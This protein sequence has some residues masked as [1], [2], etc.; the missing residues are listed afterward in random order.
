ME[1]IIVLKLMTLIVTMVLNTAFMLLVYFS[2]PKSIVGRLFGLFCFS[3]MMWLV[4]NFIASEPSTAP[5]NIFWMRLGLFFAVPQV[6]SFFLFAKAFPEDKLEISRKKLLLTMSFALSVCYIAMSPLS[7]SQVEMVNGSLQ[8]VPSFGFPFFALFAFGYAAWSVVILYRKR[9]DDGGESRNK[10]ALVLFAIFAMFGLITATIL[11][12]I[13]IWGNDTFIPFG[14]LYTMIFF[15]IV[16]FAIV[17]HRLFNIKLIATEALVFAL[18]TIYIAKIFTDETA[19][20]RYVDGVIFVA[21]LILG[22]LLTKSVQKEV[23]QREKL[24]VLTKELEGKNVQLQKL[25]RLKSEFLSFASHQVKSPMAV[26]KGYA[27]LMIDGSL[28]KASDKVVETAGKMKEVADRLIKLVNELL[29]L[30]K[31]EEG[32]MTFDMADVDMVLV[33]KSYVDELQTLAKQKKLKLT[34]ES[35]VKEAHVNADLQK[36]QQVVQNLIDNSIKYTPEGWIKVSVEEKDGQI[37]VSVSDSGLGMSKELLDNL[38]E[39]FMRDKNSRKIIQGT[40][41]GLYIAKQIVDG[42]GG[43]IWAESE[44]EGKGSVMRFTLPIL[45]STKTISTIK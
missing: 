15:G 28:G 17:K 42:H 14:P 9:N 43:K 20:A 27:Q 39:A 44:G 37:L 1:F 21:L 34:F 16:A 4:V 25:D 12:P 23:E 33:A 30:R 22:Y 2:N 10:V 40:G 35:S 13:A 36:I 8:P 7:F 24:E 31:L 6:L 41:L 5:Y 18:W 3:T 29:D 19:T 32:K 38:F 26:V 45:S 11:L